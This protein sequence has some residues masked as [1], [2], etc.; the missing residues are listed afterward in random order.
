[1]QIKLWVA[2]QTTKLF[3]RRA[4]WS[5]KLGAIEVEGASTKAKLES[6]LTAHAWA[7][8]SCPEPIYRQMK[9]GRAAIARITGCH[10][11]ELTYSI[12]H[13][14]PDGTVDGCML[15]KMPESIRPGTLPIIVM[16]VLAMELLTYLESIDQMPMPP[17]P[18]IWEK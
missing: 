4:T 2:E 11:N 7:I 14:L 3:G 1:M 13:Y 16:R 5:G 6:D 15:A 10:Q 9:D 18:E 8:L 12:T 17:H